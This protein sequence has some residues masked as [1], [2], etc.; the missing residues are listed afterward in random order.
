MPALSAV[1]QLLS[2]DIKAA[3]AKCDV[4]KK[5]EVDRLVSWT[6][7]Q[8]GGVDILVANAG[9]RAPCQTLSLESVRCT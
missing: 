3:A 8:Y 9:A 1:Q 2:A 4:T 7:E 5:A 6:V